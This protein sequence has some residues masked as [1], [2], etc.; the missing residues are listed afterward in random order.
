MVEVIP[1]APHLRGRQFAEYPRKV[2]F[3]HLHQWLR[4][5]DAHGHP[6]EMWVG[7]YLKSGLRLQTSA[8]LLLPTLSEGCQKKVKH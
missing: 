4:W 2:E 8:R 6:L 5:D 3:C 1:E 7:N